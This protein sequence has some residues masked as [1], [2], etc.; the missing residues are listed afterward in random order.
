MRAHHTIDRQALRDAHDAYQRRCEANTAAYR[1][2]DEVLLQRRGF[3]GRSTPSANA[4]TVDE[5]SARVYHH[6]VDDATR[7]ACNSDLASPRSPATRRQEAPLSEP[8]TYFHSRLV[9]ALSLYD[10][11][12]ALNHG[13]GCGDEAMLVALVLTDRYCGTARVK[14]TAHMMHRI[15]VA[16]LQ[17]GLKTHCDMFLKNSVFADIAGVS[18]TE[19]NCC[20]AALL[21]GLNWKS[22]VSSEECIALVREMLAWRAATSSPLRNRV[23]FSAETTFASPPAP[24]PSSTPTFAFVADVHLTALDKSLASTT[25]TMATDALWELPSCV[26]SDRGIATFCDVTVDPETP[27]NT[28][29]WG[30][31]HEHNDNLKLSSIRF[32]G[33]THLRTL[34]HHS[35]PLFGL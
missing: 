2:Q 33:L 29:V 20:E 24:T 14:P 32:R 11:G 10:L 28:P 35:V 23:Y 18:L 25:N 27:P 9:P 8:V 4:A 34:F 17:V 12:A 1:L 13:A 30:H 21:A 26:A 15:Y 6:S 3:R 16:C 5:L 7:S 22:L 19:L 31:D